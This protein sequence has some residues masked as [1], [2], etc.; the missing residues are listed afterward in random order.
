MADAATPAL[1]ERSERQPPRTHRSSGESGWGAGAC[2]PSMA[3]VTKEGFGMVEN[4]SL[5]AG[6]A[7]R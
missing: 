2:S 1:E 3:M 6:S 5:N 7:R 4:S